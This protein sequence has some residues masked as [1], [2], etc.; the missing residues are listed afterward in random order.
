[1]ISA[2]DV[3]SPSHDD[4]GAFRTYC[5]M[6]HMAGDDPIVMPGQ[7][8]A[9][10]LHTFFGNTAV[11]ASSTAESIQTSGNSTCHGGILN[12]SSYWVPT[13]I[14]TSRDAVVSPDYLLV[15]Y[16]S[17]YSGVDRTQIQG[18]PA[19]LR[20]VAGSMTATPSS[21]QGIPTGSIQPAAA[22][23]CNSQDTK[24]PGIPSS[25]GP[26]SD[27]TMEIAFPQC[28]DGTN[29]DSSDHQSHMAYGI[30]GPNA[31][32]DGAGCPAGYPVAIP[33]IS[34]RVHYTVPAAG[35][36]SLR[37]SSD[38][39]SGG[40]GGFSLHADW[41]NGWEPATEATWINNCVRLLDCQVDFLGN[42]TRL[43]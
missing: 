14:D 42:G 41:W 7:P 32:T 12:R 11:T 29:L 26:G 17:G 18:I 30:W 34:Y 3:L 15:Y 23:T 13:I 9:A 31:G 1:V 35:P 25:C 24:T 27:L 6:S 5:T 8:G 20:I 36:E 28:W 19:G 22:W 38:M 40:T 2:S 10:H 37:I 33:E 4:V 39:Y 16:K 43:D 21:P